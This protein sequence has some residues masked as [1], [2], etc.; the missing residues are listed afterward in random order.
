MSMEL[1]Q[2]NQ[3]QINA[4]KQYIGLCSNAI[5][6]LE[7]YKVNFDLQMA[8]AKI[9]ESSFYFNSYIMNGGAERLDE[10]PALSESVN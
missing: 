1:K 3:E 6:I 2:A 4:M 10:S 7:C 8:I 5:E 9:K